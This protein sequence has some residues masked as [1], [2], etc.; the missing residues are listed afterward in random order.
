MDIHVYMCRLVTIGYLM[1]EVGET[2]GMQKSEW[3]LNG[4]MVRS[5]MW[6]DKSRNKH[7]VCG[8]VRLFLRVRIV[9]NLD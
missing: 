1:G 7:C 6:K 5:N 8:A 3:D 4:E 9:D 2:T